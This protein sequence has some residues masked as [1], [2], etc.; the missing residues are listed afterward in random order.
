MR[1]SW[2][3]LL[4]AGLLVIV[5]GWQRAAVPLYDG[6]AL[7]DEPYRYVAPPPG[8]ATKKR[9][10]GNSE[11]GQA[12]DSFNT[13]GIYLNTDEQGP[14]VYLSF[15]QHSFAVPA[16]ATSVTAALVPLAP[17]GQAP[18]AG[19]IAGNVY[20]VTATSDAGSATFTP[21][22]GAPSYIDMRLPQGYP[23]G[24]KIVYRP[25]ATASW[26]TLPTTQV[27]NDIYEAKVPGL[28][29]FAVASHGSVAVPRHSRLAYIIGGA[30]VGL[31][32]LVFVARRAARR[33]ADG[34]AG[35]AYERD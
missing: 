28:G 5:S 25:S 31:A 12:K 32:A 22:P 4:G 8:H 20:R 29:D 3:L 30:L 2:L 7:P 10:S 14:Q 34:A 24:A 21:N 19:K 1:K 26:Q 23:P 11:S 18:A 27:G 13:D 16:S 6:V 9:P 15:T 35:H 17:D 33:S